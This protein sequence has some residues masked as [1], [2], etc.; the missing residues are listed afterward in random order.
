MASVVAGSG[1]MIFGALFAIIFLQ[2]RRY[3]PVM[4]VVLLVVLGSILTLDIVL[5]VLDPQLLK[6]LL[7]IM[8]TVSALTFVTAAIVASLKRF[9]EVRFYLYAW[10][11]CLIPAS[12]FTAQHIIGLELQFVSLYDTVRAG[13]IFDTY[14]M[15]FATF[16]QLCQSR[17]RAG[18]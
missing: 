9:R 1:V 10:V 13:L 16:N 15:R 17:L 4:L 12:L 6:K 18:R 11:A 8:I 3:H 14:M 5:W 7:V 2:T